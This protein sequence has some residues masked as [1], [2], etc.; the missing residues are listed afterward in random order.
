MSAGIVLPR[1]HVGVGH[2]RHGN[3]L[4]AFAASVAGVGQAHQL[5]R[6]FV[7]EISLQNSIFDQ[8]GFL[9]RLAFVIHIQRPAPPR[10]GAVVDHRAFFAGHAFADQPGKCRRLLAIEVGFQP[11]ADGLVQQNAGPSRTEHDF[12]VSRRSFARIE[13]QNRLP[14]G[15]FGKEL[16][17]FV[18]EEEVER[19][20]P[21]A[22]RGSTS[23]RLAAELASVFAMQETFMRA[24]GC[25]SSAN[26]PSEPTTRM[27]RSSSA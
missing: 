13:L 14:R 15:F 12:H 19:N 24:S 25:E 17:S 16:R 6:K 26:V 9:R 10:H 22:A 27:V 2:A 20:P 1:Q 23:R 8:H 11:V 21:A 4:I 5:R 7:A 3:V 18:A